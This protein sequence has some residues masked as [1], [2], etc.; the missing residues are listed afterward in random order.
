MALWLDGSQIKSSKQ[1]YFVSWYPNTT[2]DVGWYG[3]FANQTMV[4]AP[5]M[6]QVRPSNDFF[7]MSN[8]IFMALDCKCIRCCIQFCM[9][10]FLTNLK[11][12]FLKK[13]TFTKS[14]WHIKAIDVD[15]KSTIYQNTFTILKYWSKYYGFFSLCKAW[16]HYNNNIIIII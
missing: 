14:L 6:G 10:T 7:D 3:V 8:E 9:L 13:E 16:N 5:M 2:R 15:H 12:H 4:R 11:P 1:W